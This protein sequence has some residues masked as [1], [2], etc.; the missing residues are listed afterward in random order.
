MGEIP[1]LLV[2]QLDRGNCDECDHGFIVMNRPWGAVQLVES[3]SPGRRE[4]PQ[5]PRLD[6]SAR[7]LPPEALPEELRH[8]TAAPHTKANAPVGE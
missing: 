2:K 7:G 1:T 8:P 6:R 4:S 5:P 3:A